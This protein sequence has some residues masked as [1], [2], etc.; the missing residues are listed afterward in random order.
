MNDFLEGCKKRVDLLDRA[1]DNIP[2]S[3]DMNNTIQL[4]IKF[5]ILQAKTD[6]YQI[7]NELKWRKLFHEMQMVTLVDQVRCFEQIDEL[8]EEL[9]QNIYT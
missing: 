4:D 6:L 5:K 3:I 2:R 8:L 1:F 9:E 7:Y